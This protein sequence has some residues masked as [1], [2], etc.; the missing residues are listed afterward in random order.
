LSIG[1]R[2]TANARFDVDE[3]S[4]NRSVGHERLEAKMLTATKEEAR[5]HPASPI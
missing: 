3:I 4:G 2:G 1:E 5:V